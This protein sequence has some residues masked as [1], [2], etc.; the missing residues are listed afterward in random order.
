MTKIYLDI[1]ER[2]ESMYQL[3]INRREALK[4]SKAFIDYS[5]TIDI[6]HENLEDYNP[7]KKKVDSL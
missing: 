4:D 5:Q 2:I 6:V 1:K 3:L 7:T